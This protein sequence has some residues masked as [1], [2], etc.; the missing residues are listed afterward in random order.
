MTLEARVQAW[1]KVHGQG[2]GYAK[3]AAKELGT[4]PTTVRTLASKL[5]RAKI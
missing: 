4:T 1:I 2:Y 5:K 3:K